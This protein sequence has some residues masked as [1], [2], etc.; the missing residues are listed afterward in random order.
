V[1]YEYDT[2]YDGM[3]Y[4]PTWKPQPRYRLGVEKAWFKLM[5]NA[6]S[7][8]RFKC[9]NIAEPEVSTRDDV[10]SYRWSV[11]KLKPVRD[12]PLSGPITDRVPVVYLAPGAFT[13][14]KTHGDLTTWAGVGRWISDLNSGRQDLPA[15]TV[16]KV[17][18]ITAGLDSKREK[19]RAVYQYMQKHTRYVSVQLGIG[20]FQ[21]YPA[22]FVDEN[23][24]GDCKA[25][26]NYTLAL[27][28]AAGVEAKYTLVKGESNGGQIQTDFP[29]NQ[30]NHVIICVPDE[31]DSI[32]LECTSQQQ[33]FDFLG[34]F[35]SDRDVLLITGDSGVLV[36]TPEYTCNQNIQYRHAEV[37]LDEK[38][39]AT[40]EIFTKYSGLQIENA[41]SALLLKGEDLRKWYYDVLDIP[42]LTIQKIQLAEV[43]DNRLPEIHESLQTK[44]QKYMS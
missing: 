31:K 20:G 5:V 9:Q 37:R 13:F 8:P 4:Y 18:S 35:T 42:D 32:W 15:E 26:S 23:G 27:L 11:S 7:E 24:Y 40:A 1:V 21:P 33:P 14:E 44:L 28:K 39:D 41:Q 2:E 3:V 19:T 10:V 34:S 38:G 22:S 17:K 12:E 29:S 30:F 25:L 36:H 6:N 16:E 43:L